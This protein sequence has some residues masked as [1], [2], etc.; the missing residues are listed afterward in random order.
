MSAFAK[1]VK[2]RN[3]DLDML[4]YCQCDCRFEGDFF[5][6]PTCER[7]G[8]YL[9]DKEKAAKRHSVLRAFKVQIETIL[10]ALATAALILKCYC[11]LFCEK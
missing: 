3:E 10:V 1:W 11:D 4:E 5:P 8:D 7:C 6:W 2:S 9:N